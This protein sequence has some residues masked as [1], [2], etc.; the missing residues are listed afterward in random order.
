[1]AKHYSALKFI[2][3]KLFVYWQQ[4]P[5]IKL[6]QNCSKPTTNLKRTLAA[7]D[8]KDWRTVYFNRPWGFGWVF[9][10][11]SSRQRHKIS[12]SCTTQWFSFPTVIIIFFN[13]LGKKEK[14]SHSDSPNKDHSLSQLPFPAQNLYL[15]FW[16]KEH[17]PLRVYC[18]AP[19]AKMYF[20]SSFNSAYFNYV[21][22]PNSGTSCYQILLCQF[23]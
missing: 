3:S 11:S 2:N 14:R 5:S 21:L 10:S 8:I 18:S 13:I 15:V 6:M 17:K 23:S 20:I 12:L 1:M 7:A 4:P 19:K 16:F 9:F 22:S